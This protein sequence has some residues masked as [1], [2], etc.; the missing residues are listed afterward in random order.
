M[1]LSFTI[2]LAAFAA[3]ASTSQAVLLSDSDMDLY[4]DESFDLS[5]V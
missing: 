2:G 5:Y 4:E 1:K 3:L